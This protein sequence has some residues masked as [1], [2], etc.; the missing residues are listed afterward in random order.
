MY[1]HRKVMSERQSV[2]LPVGQLINRHC[3]RWPGGH[4][5]K[6]RPGHDM[7]VEA[8]NRIVSN[9]V[10]NWNGLSVGAFTL[11]RPNA[12]WN[13]Q[14][15]ALIDSLATIHFDLDREHNQPTARAHI[16]RSRHNHLT[17]MSSQFVFVQPNRWTNRGSGIGNSVRWIEPHENFHRISSKQRSCLGSFAISRWIAVEWNAS[18]S[19]IHIRVTK[20]EF[21]NLFVFF[22]IFSGENKQGK[23]FSWNQRND[24]LMQIAVFVMN[25]PWIG[26][27]SFVMAAPDNWR[28]S[29]QSAIIR[30]LNRNGM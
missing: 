20:G 9:D 5:F 28:I 10:C 8:V 22:Q 7:I 16:C 30:C 17:W 14:S 15:R 25:Q 27:S 19:S 11:P 6:H 18:H 29:K 24:L 26:C 2:T 1:G 23:C 4:R 3:V 12:K 13:R 21:R